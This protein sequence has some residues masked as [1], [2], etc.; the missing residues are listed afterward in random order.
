MG[1]SKEYLIKFITEE[2]LE[3]I[4]A[5]D[6]NRLLNDERNYSKEELTKDFK[7]MYKEVINDISSIAIHSLKTYLAF[8][9]YP[10]VSFSAHSKC[11]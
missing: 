9:V 2:E 8:D 1:K 4:L 6:F 3:N 7:N 11:T 10:E 5:E